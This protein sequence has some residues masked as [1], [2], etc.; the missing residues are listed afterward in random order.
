MKLPFLSAKIYLVLFVALMLSVYSLFNFKLYTESESLRDQLQEKKVALAKEDLTKAIRFTADKIQVSIEQ[1]TLWE[2]LVKQFKTR[3]E[4]FKTQLKHSTYWRPYYLQTG[5]YDRHRQRFDQPK[6]QTPSSASLLPATA[7]TLKKSYFTIV[8]Q[9]L[10]LIDFKPIYA[11]GTHQLLGHIGL[12]ILFIPELIEDYQLTHVDAE[13]V[14]LKPN[15]SNQTFAPSQLID[16]L[17]FKPQTDPINQSL[18]EL[19]QRFLVLLLALGLLTSFIFVIL[20]SNF[21]IRP[22]NQLTN[23][24]Q[25]L[26]KNPDRLQPPLK[27]IFIVKEF[28]R[29][30]NAIFHYHKQLVSANIEIEK[31]HQIAYEQA[32]IDPLSHVLNRRAFDENWHTQIEDYNKNPINLAFLLFD[33]DFFKAINDSYGHEI[34]DEIIRISASTFKKALPLD[35]DLYRIGGDEF[36]A[37]LK[38]R[39]PEEAL[40]IAE[41]CYHAIST[42]NFHHLGISEKVYYSIGVSIV[43]PDNRNDISLMNKHA[44]IA[45]YRA[46][47]SLQNKICIYEPEF[48]FEEEVLLSRHRVSAIVDALQHWES[49][50]MHCQK[51]ISLQEDTPPY[52]EALIRIRD[53]DELVAP[54]EILKV[55]QHRNLEIELDKSVM[56]NLLNLLKTQKIPPGEGISI[57]ISAQMLLQGNLIEELHP[58]KPFL[59]EHKIVIEILESTLISNI[60]QVTETLNLIRSQGF[61]VALDDFGSGYSSIK[62]LAWMPVDIIKFDLSLTHSLMADKKTKRIIENTAA[63][64]R[65]AGYD[66]VMEGIETEEIKQAAIKAGATHLQGYLIEKPRSIAS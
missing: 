52:S 58:F 40:K 29:L 43:T 53:G 17:N 16:F 23:Y 54:F 48:E 13:S 41:K 34:G 38:G 51:I 50:D 49:I 27:Q 65:S 21:I 61:K 32:R 63:M 5:F 18:W 30:K 24:L 66:L 19:V 14:H 62:Y 59:M 28:E 35:T 47:K 46:K 60:E 6:T 10:Y 31:Q 15:L 57:N 1:L 3:S 42:Y 7:P 25:L 9:K 12:A 20:F 56:K 36:A 39:S 22:L 8:D 64:I 45:L 2:T 33:C 44:D 37:I 4:D 26:K 11:S 55:I